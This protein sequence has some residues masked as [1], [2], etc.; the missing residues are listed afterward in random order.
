VRRRAQKT[1]GQKKKQ[2]R[3]RAVRE[4]ADTIRRFGLNNRQPSGGIT[5]DPLAAKPFVRRPK[6]PSTSNRVPGSAPADD[7]L[8]AHKWKRGAEE[9][10]STIKEM[11]LK[12]ARIGPAYNKGALQYLPPDFDK[13][14]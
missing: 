7:L 4:L 8:T 9:K 1:E 13:S 3:E 6:L 2:A 10:E 12:R 11:Q 14:D 5:P